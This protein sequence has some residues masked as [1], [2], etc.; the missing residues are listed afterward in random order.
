MQTLPT[1]PASFSALIDAGRVWIAQLAAY[2]LRSGVADPAQAR[3][4]AL[5]TIG[6]AVRQGIFTIGAAADVAFI[7]AALILVLYIAL[8][9]LH[10]P[11][12]DQ[13]LIR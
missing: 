2:F 12:A 7:G 9:L 3:R 8:H 6:H 5:V 13:P 11:H 1:Y 4:E 10:A